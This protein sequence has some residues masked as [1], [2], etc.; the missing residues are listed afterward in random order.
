MRGEEPG[1][2]RVVSAKHQGLLHAENGTR[3]RVVANE[4]GADGLRGATPGSR[5]CHHAGDVRVDPLLA[6]LAQT[7]PA[8]VMRL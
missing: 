2:R 8:R 7:I 3:A 5:D 4:H 1:N 6:P